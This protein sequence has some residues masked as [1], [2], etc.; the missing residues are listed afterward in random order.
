MFIR[1][2]GNRSKLTNIQIIDKRSGK[3]KF[4][5]MIGSSKN[6]T[7]MENLVQKDKEWIK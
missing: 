2:K 5:K 6:P 4:I 3:Y 1:K 7:E